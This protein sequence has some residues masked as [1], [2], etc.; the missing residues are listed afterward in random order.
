MFES[1]HFQYIIHWSTTSTALTTC[2]FECS[3]TF[4][5][6]PRNGTIL[7]RTEATERLRANGMCGKSQQRPT[8][9]YGPIANVNFHGFLY[10]VYATFHFPFDSCVYLWKSV[11]YFAFFSISYPHFLKNSWN[12]V[13]LKYET[14]K[15]IL[16]FCNI[17][18]WNL[19][20]KK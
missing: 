12:S 7:Q 4:T 16:W 9:D 3:W 10:C 19:L 15:V 18:Q 6:V 13:V 11:S 2:T 8:G 20:L 14:D 17:T 1:I 5:M